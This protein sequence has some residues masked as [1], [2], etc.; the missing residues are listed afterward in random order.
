MGEDPAMNIPSTMLDQYIALADRARTLVGGW[1]LTARC[2]GK[3]MAALRSAVQAE[4]KVRE[5]QRHLV[6]QMGGVVLAGPSQGDQIDCIDGIDIAQDDTMP[7]AQVAFVQ[8]K[9]TIVR[10][11]VV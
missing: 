3:T 1:R 8:G 11:R 2:S 9:G 10:G 6:Y 4:G 5:K 7:D